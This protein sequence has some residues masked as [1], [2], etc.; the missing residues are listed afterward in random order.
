VLKNTLYILL[1]WSFFIFKLYLHADYSYP[2]KFVL[3]IALFII[4]AVVSFIFIKK[5]LTAYKQ[6]QSFNTLSPLF[7]T[8]FA[9]IAL[10][11]TRYHLSE[12][13]KA[14]TLLYAIRG[15]DTNYTITIDLRN[16]FS[17]KIGQEGF[18]TKKYY[19]GHYRFSDSIIYLDMSYPAFNINSTALLIRQLTPQKGNR[20]EQFLANLLAVKKKNEEYRYSL[21]PL[22]ADGKIMDSLFYYKVIDKP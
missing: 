10:I 15:S 22:A 3:D 17:Y 13:D 19:R 7:A 6:T 21:V 11:L 9:V 20:N 12:R 14:G 5:G 2:F 8:L 18:M 1:L 4:A 16:D